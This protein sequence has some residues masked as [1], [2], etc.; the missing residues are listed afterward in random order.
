MLPP[1]P[2]SKISFCSNPRDDTDNPGLGV[3]W[4]AVWSLQST[5]RKLTPILKAFFPWVTETSSTSWYWVTD[6]PWGKKKAKGKSPDVVPNG[7]SAE[8]FEVRIP[9][10]VAR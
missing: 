7:V 10:K 9:G 6:R 4:P 3:S 2:G 5:R 8:S 1:K